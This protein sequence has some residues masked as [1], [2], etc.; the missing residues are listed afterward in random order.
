M[1]DVLKSFKHSST[2][3]SK[4]RFSELRW[5]MVSNE[6]MKKWITTVC[7]CH[8]EKKYQKSFP[9]S[10]KVRIAKEKTADVLAVLEVCSA[11]GEEEAEI[12][13]TKRVLL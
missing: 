6:L 8:A 9:N 12:L 7:A 5:L 3:Y 11:E 10:V 13:R 2:I 1:T 4:G